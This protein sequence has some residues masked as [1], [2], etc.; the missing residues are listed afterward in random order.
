M[1]E[2]PLG[3]ANVVIS[4]IGPLTLCPNK[5]LCHISEK[6]IKMLVSKDKIL[7]LKKVEVGFLNCM[8]SRIRKGYF[9]KI[10]EDTQG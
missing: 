3:E 6:G 9:F 1:V 10:K 8:C 4:K 2:L 7:E 5:K